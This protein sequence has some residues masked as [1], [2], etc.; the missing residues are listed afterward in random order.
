[1]NDYPTQSHSAAI[2][3][4][5]SNDFSSAY[6]FSD[7]VQNTP[8]ESVS[9]LENEIVQITDTVTILRTSF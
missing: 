3:M 6:N 1:M 8:N 4:P 9:N 2:F 7:S 5:I